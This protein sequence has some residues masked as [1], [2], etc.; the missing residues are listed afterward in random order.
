M[1]EPQSSTGSPAEKVKQFPTTAGI[2]LMKDAQAPGHLRRQSQE[3]AQR[4]PARIFTRPP[5][6]DRRICDWIGEVA[7]I[8][9]LAADSEVDALLDGSAAGQGHSAQ[10][11]PRP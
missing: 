7:D 11:Q 10:V 5:A 3:P 6:G 4:G 9:F 2:Y 8:E 1:S